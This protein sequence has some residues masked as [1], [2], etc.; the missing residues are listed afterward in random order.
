MKKY[1]VAGVI[2]GLFFL[3]LIMGCDN[4]PTEFD[5]YEKEAVLHAFVV[6]DHHFEPVHLEWVQKNIFT[7]YTT[8]DNAIR[9]DDVEVKIFPLS[10]THEDGTVEE[11]TEADQLDL[12][13]DFE[14]SEQDSAYAPIAEDAD[15]IVQ[16]MTTYR[17]EATVGPEGDR[18]VDIWAETTTPRS[19]NLWVENTDDGERYQA[20]DDQIQTNPVEG[21]FTDEQLETIPVFDR[22]D[23]V[24]SIAWTNAWDVNPD[25][26]QLGSGMIFTGRMMEPWETVLRLDPD[27]DPNDH[28]EDEEIDPEEETRSG[29]TIAPDYQN[30]FDII[31]FFFDYTGPHRLEA[32][33]ASFDYYRYMFTNLP[34]SPVSP[35]PP[36]SNINGGLGVFGGLSKRYFYFAL[37]R[38]PYA[39]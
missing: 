8:Y 31:W 25:R 3:L 28:D 34:G 18:E 21:E 26:S 11:Y 22:D 14:W 16:P 12:T 6:V 13:V 35:I 39:K 32:Q 23:P 33:A 7:Y 17:I 5:D 2:L 1:S 38:V 37:E 20:I 19:F 15:M 27:W 4:Q 30:S 9:G 29:W 36:E 24:I 10:V